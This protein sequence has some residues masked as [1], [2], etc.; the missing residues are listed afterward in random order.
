MGHLP[1]MSGG[2]TSR[3]I[4]RQLKRSLPPPLI[5]VNDLDHAFD[6]YDIELAFDNLN[7]T[8]S[9]SASPP[10]S[11]STASR[12]NLSDLILSFICPIYLV[13]E[14]CLH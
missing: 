4:R 2:G 11:T 13:Y 14:L 12:Y 3:R 8:P 6:G 5:N 10:P 1:S 7:L 9:S